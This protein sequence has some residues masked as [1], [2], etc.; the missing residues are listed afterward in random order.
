MNLLD[1][2]TEAQQRAVTFGDG[3]L[4]V[5][6]CAGSGKTR[7]IT[8]RVVHLIRTGVNPF[9]IL[10]ITFT[11]KASSEMASRVRALGAARG[12]WISTFHAFCARMLRRYGEVL[13][14]GR[15]F[16][17]FDQSD[18]RRCVKAALSELNLDATNWSP[19]AIQARISRLKNDLLGP[20]DLAAMG[21]FREKTLAR[22]MTRYEEIL[23]RN[24][25]LDFDDL[26]GFMARLLDNEAARG[27]L[28]SRFQHILIDEY[29]D[30]NRVQYLIAKGLAGA[31]RNICAT[32]DP[33]QSIYGWRGAE[34]RNILDF[35]RDFP[36]AVVIKLEE[37]FRSTPQVLSAAEG[38][39]SNNR[40]RIE[41][42]LWTRLPAG[43]RVSVLEC[44]DE[45][46]EARIVVERIQALIRDGVP[47]AECAIFYRVNAMSRA[48]EAAAGDAGLRYCIVSG[49]AFYQRKEIKDILAYLRVST[50]PDDDI[51][52][53]RIVN[54]PPRGIG[55][56][57]LNRLRASAHEAGTSLYRTVTGRR[58]A[59]AFSKGAEKKVDALAE[60]LQTLAQSMTLPAGKAVRSVIKL[61]GY[62]MYVNTDR[63]SER[64]ENINELVS[65]AERFEAGHPKLG[66]AAFLEN[67]ALVSDIDGWDNSTDAAVMM[68]V[69][70]AKG[71]EFEHVFIIGLEEGLFPHEFSSGSTDETEEERRLCYVALTRAK[72]SATLTHTRLR[73]LRGRCTLRVPSRFL[74]ELPDEA[75]ERTGGSSAGWSQESPDLVAPPE[76]ARLALAPGDMVVHNTFG[77]GRVVAVLGVGP[78][79]RAT[80]RFYE[81]G[82]RK[83]VLKYAGLV[84][85]GDVRP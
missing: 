17:I 65:A 76:T 10:A 48:L 56:V 11:N 19:T 7:V 15:D 72:R 49:T 83:L 80:V 26:L 37:N 50:N 34:I 78:N 25:A 28:H 64:L 27:E 42:K 41:R 46:D 43:A 61:S 75:V 40:A 12:A 77:A 23:R 29:Q 47:P 45:E 2:L 8:R 62:G 70:A 81:G 57:T 67:A 36:E 1:D 59:G 58:Y 33:D 51:S 52:F 39:I 85:T 31:R 68:T 9:N 73:M 3:P 54:T 38:L 32:G 14:I 24:G 4:L 16:T 55:A 22:I 79:A 20:A 30:T 69:H 53:Q 35:E 6:A 18:S 82:T 84:K 63:D 60:L 44:R 74:D 21:G 71:L 13:G 66:I 5:V